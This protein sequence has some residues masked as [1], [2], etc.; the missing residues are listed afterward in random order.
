MKHPKDVKRKK[1]VDPEA[2]K[3]R[4]DCNLYDKSFSRNTRLYVHRRRE[5]PEVIKRLG[6]K[7]KFEK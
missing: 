7:E 4:I 2:V 5:H 1:K 6:S 3:R